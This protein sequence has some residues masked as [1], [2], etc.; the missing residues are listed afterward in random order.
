MA[1]NVYGWPPLPR[2]KFEWD[3]E[4]PISKSYS[5][6]TGARYVSAYKPERRIARADVSALAGD[7]N[8]AGWV[9]ALKRLLVG[10]ENLVRIESWPV[11]WCYDPGVDSTARKSVLVNWTENGVNVDWT[12]GGVG[13]VWYSGQVLNGTP[14]TSGGFPAIAVSGLPVNQLV[15]RPGELITIFDGAED[16]SPETVQAMAPARSDASGEAVIRVFE[17]VTNSGRVNIGSTESLVFEVAQALPRAMQNPRSD[18]SFAWDFRE[19]FADE[20]GGF[21]E[22]P[23]W[24]RET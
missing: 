11:N 4:A 14:A 18:W 5:G 20:V 8:S 15:V 7:G 1:A 10:G 19:V 16:A 6:V 23:N 9:A 2:I 13:A 3:R 24:W 21:T 12:E 17:T 22:F